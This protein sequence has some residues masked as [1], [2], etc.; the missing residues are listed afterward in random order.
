MGGFQVKSSIDTWQEA[1]TPRRP[2]VS[3]RPPWSTAT[4]LQRARRHRRAAAAG[5]GQTPTT[6]TV[7]KA[8]AATDKAADAFD[9]AAAEHARTSRASSAGSSCSARS[10]PSWRRSA[11]TAYT[12][13]L[14]RRADRR[15]LRRRSQHPLMEFS[16]ELGLGTG[17][18]TS[19]GRTVY[20]I[21]LTKAAVSLERVHRHAPAD[22]A[23]PR[24]GR[25]SP[26]SASPSPRTPTS[27]AS[28]SRS[29]SRGGTAAG[30]ARSSGRAAEAKTQGKE[31]A[32][33]AAQGRG[34]RAGRTCRRRP[35]RPDGHGAR[36][37]LHDGPSARAALAAKG[38]TR[39]ELVGGQHRSSTTPTAR[40]SRTSPTRP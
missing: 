3:C 31:L 38:I 1:R 29:T 20:A 28:P 40:S 18:I 23:R 14:H 13:K 2:R 21:S 24:H 25:A 15:G 35:T 7:V 33:Q 19:Y 22:Q 5:Q 16:N 10:S 39:R 34:R 12:S 36:R 11:A 17:N 30:R 37:A 6:P 32:A 4:P 8:R 9:K 26:A 27:R